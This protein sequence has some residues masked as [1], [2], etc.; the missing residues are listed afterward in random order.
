MS[1]RKDEKVIR[2][3]LRT[4]D[5]DKVKIDFHGGIFTP[6]EFTSL[7]MGVLETYTI[8][9]MKTNSKEAV[10]N[11]WNNVFGIF[12]NKIVPEKTHYKLS[13]SHKEFKKVVYSTLGRKE[14]AED[15]KATED[16]KMAAYLLCRDILT[17]EIGLD[18][19]SADVILNKRL[20]IS[21]PLAKPDESAFK[22]E[23]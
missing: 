10:F 4:S 7:F 19:D 20:G 3:A 2:I 21:S 15:K 13:R 23:K 6:E 1:N 5:V 17:K 12:L 16:N 11:H 22:K 14:T 8:G 18:E 9:L